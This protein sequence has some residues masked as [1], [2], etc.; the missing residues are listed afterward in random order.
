MPNNKQALKRVRQN[1]TRRMENKTVR[2]RMRKSIKSVLN[3]DTADAATAALPEA[4]KRIDKAAKK[5][6]I[7]A[8]AADR[9]KARLARNI[10]AKG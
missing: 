5:N 2:T 8:N 3:A 10:A 4:M 6:V 7:H 1:E 9:Y